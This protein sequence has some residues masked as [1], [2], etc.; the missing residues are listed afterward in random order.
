MRP[1]LFLL[2]F[3]NI[4]FSE[5]GSLSGRITDLKNSEVLIGANV[6]VKGTTLGGATDIQ[7]FS[8]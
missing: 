2:I 4:A 5:V 3:V 6:V 8:K 7:I 1:L